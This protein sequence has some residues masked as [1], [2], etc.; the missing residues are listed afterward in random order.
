MTI[1]KVR[2]GDT[3]KSIAE[4]FHTSVD[5]IL[6]DNKSAYPLI[7]EDYYFVGWVLKV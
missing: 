7:A 6:H 1:Y 4:A 2:K 5:K 3:L